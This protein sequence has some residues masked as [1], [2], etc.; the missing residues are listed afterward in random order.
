MS[1]ATKRLL[2]S[3]STIVITAAAG[4]WVGL[5]VGRALALRHTSARLDQFANQ[6]KGEAESSSAESRRI[7]AQLNASPYPR[8]SEADIAYARRAVFQSQY[9]KDAGRMHDGVIACSATLGRM[10]G[11]SAHYDPL[12]ARK[13]GTRVYR[14]LAPF[15]MADRTI[16]SVGLG[17]AYIT[18]NP[19]NLRQMRAIPIHLAVLDRDMPSGQPRELMGD[20]GSLPSYLLADGSSRRADVLFATHCSTVYSSCITAYVSV[21]DALQMERAEIREDVLLF[22]ISGGLLG[23]A[24][25]FL[26]RR[27]HSLERQLRRAIRRETLYLLYQPIFDL[28]SGT[29]VGAEALARWKDEDGYQVSPE[30]FIKIAEDR[31][32]VGEITRFVVR[33][34]VSDLKTMLQTR[35]DFRVNVNIAAA[36]LADSHFV[37][38]LARMLEEAGVSPQSLGIE[39]TESSTAR[40]QVA[41]NAILQLRRMGHLAHIDD[42]GT[43][44]SS[45][46]YLHDLSVDVIKIDKAFTQSIGTDSLK[47]SILPQILS[48]AAALHLQVVV[49][50]VETEEQAR[51]FSGMNQ[52]VLAQGWLLGRPMPIEGLLKLLQEAEETLNAEA[53]VGSARRV[54][55]S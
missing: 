14:D 51:Y 3:L 17:D 30:I 11:Q 9:L 35:P 27:S 8:C 46:A 10:D 2:G 40:Q 7:L 49:E 28:S 5:I 42:F 16:V 39:I 22:G 38:M 41:Q 54:S 48:M 43:G 44:Y 1:S 4:A 45:L 36:D 55:A 6:V 12:F 23:L 53:V 20:I 26:Y 37:P 32:F 24:L 25:S 15:R 19:F 33:R 50:G 29:I 21:A 13:D 34:A 52:P 18:Y 31:G 47:V